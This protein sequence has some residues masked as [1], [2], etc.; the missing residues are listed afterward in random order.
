VSSASQAAGAVLSAKT[1]HVRSSAQGRDRE[2]LFGVKRN[3]W[4]TSSARP[5]AAAAAPPPP[6]ERCGPIASAATAGGSVRIPARCAALVGLKPR[7]G[8]CRW[9]RFPGWDHV[10]RRAARANR[11]R[12]RGS[13]RRDRGGDDR[14][15]R[16]AAAAN[17]AV[18]RRVL[19]QQSRLNVAWT[20]DLG[21]ARVEAE[22]SKRTGD[23]AAEFGRSVAR[24][25]RQ[26]GWRTSR[27]RSR[28]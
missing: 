24:G 6:S 7:T 21:F 14:D 23:A 16:F 9:R 13:A 22:C 8:A 15:Q 17:A 4:K 11:A 10:A 25:G 19:G 18:R 20:P 28:R 2:P 5:A 1:T 3:P 27:R 26:S 12:R